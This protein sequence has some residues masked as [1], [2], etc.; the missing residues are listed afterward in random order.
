MIKNYI[1]ILFLA[2]LLVSNVWSQEIQIFKVEDFD[3]KG[4]VKSCLVITDY[5]KELFEFNPE[6]ILTKTVTQYNDSDQDITYYKYSE[7]ELIEKR[8]E[9]YKNKVL[10]EATSM[11]NFYTIDTV[12]QR[13]VLEKIIS[14]DKEFLEQQEYIFD[15]EGKLIK[16]ITSNAE[17]VDETTCEYVPYKNEL[18]KSIF[19]NGVLE[20]SM[21]TSE[22]KSSKGTRQIVLT[23]EYVDGE[24]NA[25][26]E[27]ILDHEGK[28]ASEEIFSYDVSK[29]KFVTDKK[30]IYSYTDGVLERVVTRTANT[31]SVQ[32]YIFQ[33]DNN[34]EKNWVRKIISPDNT[35]TSRVITYYP[36]EK[37][38]EPQ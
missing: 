19:S 31:E 32:D 9:S 12:P 38:E 20:R 36:E 34:P 30:M 21:R 15:D 23:K 22:Q 37:G 13:K 10:D 24:P 35:Y 28:L 1:A 4:N 14:Y 3:L 25:A 16:I 11:A 26:Q 27:Q 2:F 17:G 29:K 5:G 33:F 7:G 8:M 6:G 18:T